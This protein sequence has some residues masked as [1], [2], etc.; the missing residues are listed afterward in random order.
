MCSKTILPALLAVAIVFSSFRLWASPIPID[1]VKVGNPG[2]A[3]DTRR[4]RGGQLC[5]QDRH[6]RRDASPIHGFLNAVASTDTY[7]LYDT[8]WPPT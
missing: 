5:L 1:T 7:G 8:T 4:L 2:N 6:L 3:A